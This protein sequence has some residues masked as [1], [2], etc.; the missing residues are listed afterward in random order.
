MPARRF[1]PPWCRGIGNDACP[2]RSSA[3]ELAYR[4][5]EAAVKAF[6]AACL[7]PVLVALAGWLVLN[8]AQEPVDRAFATAPYTR[9]GD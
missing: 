5:G 3:K 2:R 1:P 7:V 6:L 9:V 4:N 8:D